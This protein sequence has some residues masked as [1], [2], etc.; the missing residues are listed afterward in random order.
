MF[1]AIELEQPVIHD[2]I[3]V[4]STAISYT[5]YGDSVFVVQKH[6]NQAQKDILTVKRVYV[7]PGEI[8]GNYTV[9]KKGLQANQL[10]V[11]AGELK[12][13]DGTE[14]ILDSNNVLVD[15]NNIDLLGE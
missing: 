14:V 5:M 13:Q 15:H 10:V 9:I 1:S 3:A 12:L 2:V 11:S 8:H 7:T 4:P 6:Q